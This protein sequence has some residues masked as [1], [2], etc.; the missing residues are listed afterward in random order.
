MNARQGQTGTPSGVRTVGAEEELLLVDARDGTPRSVASRALRLA[1]F[2][3]ETEDVGDQEAA[4]GGSLG[5]ELQEQQLETD[6]P[7]EEDLAAL[8]AE[9]HRWRRK[10][11]S[12]AEDTG[13]L[14]LASG[15]AP[16]SVR[17]ETV[18]DARFHEITRRFGLTATEQLSCGFHVHVSVD[19]DDEAV[20]VLNRIRVWLPVLL[21]LSAN[22]PFWHG[23]DSG[24]ASYRSRVMA[25][26]PTNGPTEVFESGRAY[27]EHLD[28]L[29]STGVPLDQ[30]MA[31]FD[32]RA[33]RRYPTVEVRVADVCLDPA[34]AVL[35]AAL[36]RA[37]VDRA[38]EEWQEGKPAPAASVTLLR[39][40]M[41]QASRF[42][43]SE[44]LLH[45]GTH[46]PMASEQVV[47]A[48][49]EHVAPALCRNGDE[50][51]VTAQWERI[52]SRGTGSEQQRE[53]AREERDM[54]QLAVRLAELSAGA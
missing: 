4:P 34:D 13:A 1:R 40:V 23:E 20:A 42:G 47:E 52:R 11:R 24:Y 28:L 31:Y 36:S 49:L 7:P 27:D 37:L 29:T 33:S 46:R 26:W 32:A 53:V 39:L 16:R 25:R 21:A 51:R 38:V 45:P 12:A 5:P 17:P 50:A 30:G 18:N 19:S 2:R 48:L 3:G 6:T 44:Q 9:L 8:E 22:S 54:G 35:N 41:W 43:I 14:V 10:A 15:T